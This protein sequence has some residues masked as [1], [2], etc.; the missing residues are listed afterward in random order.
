MFIYIFNYYA[1]IDKRVLCSVVCYVVRW[2]LAFLLC[3]SLLVFFF[4]VVYVRFIF[5]C[6]CVLRS[7]G[8]IT[9][10]I[11]QKLEK[12]ITSNTINGMRGGRSASG[13]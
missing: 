5:A 6:I 13:L 12:G 11:F 4:N 2:L 7:D 3:I 1:Y 9:N 8:G 10:P